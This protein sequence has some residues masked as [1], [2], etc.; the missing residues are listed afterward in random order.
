MKAEKKKYNIWTIGCQ[1]NMA[2]S[3]RLA[4][5]LEQFGYAECARADES[6][7]VVLNTC[8]VRDSAE[9]KVKG[10][11]QY[12]QGLKKSR[13]DM[14]IVLMGCFVGRGS[15]PRIERDYPF[16]DIFMP[17]S[18]ISPLEEQLAELVSAG[19]CMDDSQGPK[20]EACYELP[21]SASSSISAN[22][23]AVLGCS[24][25]CSYCII[26][27]RRGREHSRP[28]AEILSEVESLAQQG[29]REIILLGQIVDRY[30]TDF[31]HDYG[32]GDLLRETAA[33]AGVLRVRF[34]TS[35]PSSMSDDILAAVAEEEKVCPHFEL[36]CQ[37]GDDAMLAAMRRGYTRGEYRQIVNRI[38]ARIPDAAINTDI[39]VGFPGESEAQF[40]ESCSLLE[41]IRFDTV[42]VAKYSPR[43]QTY[44]ARHCSDDVPAE[45]KE[46]RRAY[47]DS[48]HKRILAEKNAALLG[49]EQEVLIES[50]DEKHGR[51]RG[52]SPQNK[53]IFIEGGS[54]LL[55][56]L[57]RARITWTGPFSMLAETG[58]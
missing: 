37:H 34:L 48:I 12:L 51:W 18:D 28:R 16:V 23:P 43:P 53:L 58:A 15:N 54:D 38:R 22:V 10:K 8:V 9:Q 57:V 39:I 5:C 42:H 31:T 21:Q 56:E 27:Y 44:A 36:P 7:M 25:A 49:S 3:R 32:L 24:H 41:E 1:M 14:K 6:D 46:R 47:L 40:L 17:P 29:V 35:H 4:G 33:P 2:D 19:S 55:G 26:P 30:G 20:A 52:R 11:L 13:P 45:E 50:R